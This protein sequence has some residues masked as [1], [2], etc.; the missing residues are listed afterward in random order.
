M[1]KAEIK[2]TQVRMRD[3]GFYDGEID[4]LWG[5]LTQ[6]GF[7]RMGKGVKPAVRSVPA[8][9][10]WDQSEGRLYR[11]NKSIAVGYSGKGLGRNNPAMESIK[12]TGP[13]PAGQ[14][15]IGKPRRSAATGPH[16]MDLRPNGHDA[17]GRSAFQI[18][19]DNATGTASS[20]CI[21]LPRAIREMISNSGDNALTVI[22]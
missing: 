4:G 5:P 19:G 15:F 16:A 1:T 21:I 22:Q 20:G 8:G 17:H 3:Q 10:V 13:L 11:N 14:W 7:E 12:A 9:W 2:A 18:H 6:N